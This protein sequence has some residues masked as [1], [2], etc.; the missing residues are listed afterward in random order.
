[1]G[2][3]DLTGACHAVNAILVPAQTRLDLTFRF[4]G[5]HVRVSAWFWI[6]PVLIGGFFATWLGVPYLLLV[7]GCFFVSVLLHEFGHVLAGRYFGQD[8]Y[9]VL[10]SIGGAAVGCADA[11]ERWQ[12]IVVYLAGP[13]IQ[14]VCAGLLWGT[15]LVVLQRTKFIEGE[16]PLAS[17]A[18][19]ALRFINFGMALLSLLPLPPI[20]DGWHI[21]RELVEG[22]KERH[23]QPWEQNPDWWRGG[24]GRSE[25]AWR[26]VPET[27][28]AKSNRL[29]LL[30]LTVAV[31]LVL[32]WHTLRDYKITTATDLMREFR[33]DP[34][35]MEKY[36][37][38]RITFNAVLKRPRW[39]KALCQY[40][41]GKEALIY[42]VTDSP[43]E[44]LFCILPYDEGLR[45]LK[46]GGLYRV[47]GE[48]FYFEKEGKL[49]L[50]H[51]S[52]KL[53]SAPPTSG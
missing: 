15:D 30:V 40:E 52:V 36:G 13:L 7:V 43:D 6:M 45:N 44:W 48:I 19:L 31:S 25:Y 21:C 42:F 23:R 3:A 9:I 16:Y 29:P 14:L 26:P 46:E 18:L 49:F 51:C 22:F 38:R 33:S 12:R 50:H 2:V 27:Y 32:G 39:E 20:S 28:G 47:S 5:T 4:L 1:L 24:I 10:N 53:I 8:G 37:H 41:G 35:A 17:H 11:H 34:G